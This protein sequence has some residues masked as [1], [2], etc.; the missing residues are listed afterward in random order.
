MKRLILLGATGSIGLRTLE[1]VS[2]FPDEFSVA[3]IAARGSNVERIADIC[4][5]YAPRAV[6]L[7]DTEARD[8]LAGLLPSP[9]P[10]LLAGVKG[11]V[12]L[13]RAEAGRRDGRLPAPIGP[14]VM[15]SPCRTTSRAPR[16]TSRSDPN[17]APLVATH[18]T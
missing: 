8:R 2:S 14:I 6:A 18:P 17:I 10:E 11:L 4:R 3:G 7:L 12:A 16:A 15:M 1:L 9:R 13:V 5:K